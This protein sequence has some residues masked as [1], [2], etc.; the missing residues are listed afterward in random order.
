MTQLVRYPVH[1]RCAVRRCAKVDPELVK[2]GT[3]G[4]YLETARDYVRGGLSVIPLHTDGSKRPIE[5]GWQV[6]CEHRPA[7]ADLVR[8]FSGRSMA[9]IGV[10]CGRAS[11]GLEVMDIEYAELYTLYAEQ[12]EERSPGLLERL[13][14]VR[15]GSGAFHIYYRTDRIESGRR[16]AVRPYT[17][18]QLDP[19]TGEV[20]RRQKHDLLIETRAHGQ[21]V[22]AP[23]SCPSCHP[24]GN[25][26]EH[27]DG[28]P[29]VD[30]PRITEQDRETLIN[31]AMAFTH[32]AETEDGMP[33]C[34]AP[35]FSNLVEDDDRE[36]G[37]EVKPGDDFNA[38]G[39]WKN[40]LEPYDWRLVREKDGVGYWRRPGKDK[41]WSATTNYAGHDLLIVFSEN[42]PPFEVWK[43][44][45]SGK[46]RGYTKFAAFMLLRH[47]GDYT[48]GSGVAVEA[49][50]GE[51]EGQARHDPSR[52]NQQ[53]NNAASAAEEFETIR[54]TGS[55]TTE[56]SHHGQRRR[57]NS[58][59]PLARPT[60]S[61]L[62]D[63]DRRPT[64]HHQEYVPVLHH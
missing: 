42:A 57:T 38:R 6:Y 16:L 50:L 32:E 36:S 17:E 34:V 63:D 7:D 8:W 33:P 10:P 22:V 56:G 44:F 4:R 26:Y 12:V 37:F 60:P 51:A 25:P 24:S 46:R 31:V 1:A 13:P 5:N 9:G 59:I 47:G 29:L 19:Q 43:D 58:G 41:Y 20:R 54:R 39:E 40:I 14:L 18:E 23:G 35:D 27:V 64:G 49:G 15:T 3:N 21:Q 30:A 61:R 11:G 45:R 52:H 53:E 2:E 62:P 48:K 28:P 55:T